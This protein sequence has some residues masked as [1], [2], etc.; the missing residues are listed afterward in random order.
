MLFSAPR[1]HTLAFLLS[2]MLS[3]SVLAVAG[4]WLA[5][6]NRD[7]QPL[8]PLPKKVASPEDNPPSPEKI[9]LGKQLFFDPRLSGENNM[10]CASCHLPQKALADGK[11]VAQGHRGKALSR[12]TPSLWNVGFSS[13]LHWDGRAKNLEEQALLPIQSR[14]EMN[15]DLDEL[16]REL[17]AI[18]GYVQHFEKVF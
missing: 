11:A 10:S 9:A 1:A 5:A 18:P 13:L 4:G 6:A 15:Q 8:A 7:S 14:D 2:A 12:N 16:E 3:A 17:S